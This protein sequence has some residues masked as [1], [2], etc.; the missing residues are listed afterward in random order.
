MMTKDIHGA[1]PQV[2]LSQVSPLLSRS[3]VDGLLKF[4]P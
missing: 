1:V 4:G 2:D 3:K